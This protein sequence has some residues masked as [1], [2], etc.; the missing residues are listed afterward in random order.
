MKWADSVILS[1]GLTY[2][3]CAILKPDIG[4]TYFGVSN[5]PLGALFLALVGILILLPMLL[6]RLNT[7]TSLSQTLFFIMGCFESI[8]VVLSW[9]SIVLWNIPA[10]GNQALFQISMA[11]FDWVAAA[12]LFMKVRT[13]PS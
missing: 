1:W 8:G 2:L 10:Y 5:P 9:T 13:C 7:L 4:G 6:E 11:T 12:A 3:A